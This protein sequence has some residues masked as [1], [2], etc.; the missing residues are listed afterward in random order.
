MDQIKM[1]ELSHDAALLTYQ[2]IQKGSY[3]GQN[4]PAKIQL[5]CGLCPAWWEVAEHI[6]PGDSCHMGQRSQQRI[7]S[8]LSSGGL[9]RVLP[10][11]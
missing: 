10:L 5:S 1:L 2:L 7:A 4:L 3:K 9:T 6:L 8:W 11:P